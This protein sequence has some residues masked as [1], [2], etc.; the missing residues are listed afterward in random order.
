MLEADN[1]DG[2]FLYNDDERAVASWC[3]HNQKPAGAYTDTLSGAG[4]FYIPVVSQGESLGVIGLSCNK[5]KPSTNSK[6]FLQLMASQAAMALGRQAVSDAQRKASID[7]EK[8]KMRSNLLRA[9]S[10]DLRT[11]LTGIMGASSTILENDDSLLKSEKDS[12]L[13]NIKDSSEWLIRMVENL[14][15]VTRINDENA[16]ITKSPEVVEEIVAETVARVRHRFS[17]VDITTQIPDE[18]I[19]IP[20][21]GILIEQVLLNFIDNSVKHNEGKSPILLSVEK[22]KTG[23]QFNVSDSGKGIPML[24][25]RHLFD[26]VA[27]KRN[28]ADSATGLGIGLSIC[29]S[30]IDAHGG[31]IFATNNKGGGAT[32]S[33]VLPYND[34]E[35]NNYKQ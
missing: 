27:G 19:I 26:G 31:K 10:H 18:M 16:E 23:V 8:E 21:D 14:L 15:S 30:I 33:F 1:D 9:I 20:M 34:D 11:P 22:A 29:K 3:Y 32:F 17:N 7:S 6:F 25:I 28:R 12:L 4:A 35:G 2:G 24:E 13:H 5:G